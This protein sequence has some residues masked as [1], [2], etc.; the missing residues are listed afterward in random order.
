MEQHSERRFP[1]MAALLG[2]LAVAGYQNRD[3]LLELLRKQGV[4]AQGR[5]AGAATGGLG[6]LLSG[7]LTELV[8]RFRSAGHGEAA[9]SWVARGAN[10]ELAPPDLER[11]IGSN[12]LDDLAT[13]TGLSRSEILSRLSRDLPQAV[14]QY[15]PEGRIP[16]HGEISQ[17]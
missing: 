3:K 6:G 14:D 10:K 5:S 4:G 11:A 2:V 7:G 16:T 9:D 8:E 13:H 17:T 15:T 1:S 12:V